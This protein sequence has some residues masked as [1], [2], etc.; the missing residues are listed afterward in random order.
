MAQVTIYMD[1]ETVSRMRSAAKEAE[2]SVSAWLAQLVRERTRSEWPIEVSS[3]FGAW[4][5][6][7]TAEEIRASDGPDSVREPP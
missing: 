7:P 6:L 2:L 1:E 4:P 3:L 5:D